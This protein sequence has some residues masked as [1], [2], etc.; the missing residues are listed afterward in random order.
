MGATMRSFVRVSAKEDDEESSFVSMT[1]LAVSFLFIVMLLMAF[2]ATRF[3]DKTPDPLEAYLQRAAEARL[4]VLEAL[5]NGIKAQF[6]NLVVQISSQGDALQLQGEGLFATNES[7]LTERTRRIVQ[8]I[9]TTLHEVLPCYT[10]GSLTHWREECNEHYAI[11]DAVQIEGHTDTQGGELANMSLSTAR[12]NVTFGAMVEHQRKLTE[13]RNERG[14]PVLSVA[15]YGWM[16]PVATNESD[17]G[18]SRNRRIDLRLIMF[19]PAGQQDVERVV[20]RLREK[21]DKA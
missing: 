3:A 9:A 21:M 8:A 10:L 15:G 16:R 12:A 6:P 5:R 2:F 4:Q 11:I 7:E 1:D 19:T 18:R 20:N 13:H 14:F 17:E